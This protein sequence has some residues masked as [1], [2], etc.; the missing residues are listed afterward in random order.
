MILSIDGISNPV[1]G[2]LTDCM[3]PAEIKL[4]TLEIP[5]LGTGIFYTGKEPVFRSYFAEERGRNAGI[6]REI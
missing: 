6:V 2:G 3:Q 5:V 4:F 1:Y